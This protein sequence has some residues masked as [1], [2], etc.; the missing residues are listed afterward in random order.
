[1]AVFSL[2]FYFISCCWNSN[3]CNSF[4]LSDPTQ[5]Y[6]FPCTGSCRVS[7]FLIPSQ[8]LA[9]RNILV[10]FLAFQGR[11]LWRSQGEWTWAS[12]SFS[13]K[14]SPLHPPPPQGW[15]LWKIGLWCIPSSWNPLRGPLSQTRQNEDKPF[16]KKSAQIYFR[17]GSFL[18]TSYCSCLTG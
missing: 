11:P 14:S 5:W 7:C 6:T 9:P 13:F 2:I 17:K 3:K 1:M 12:S 10:D 8:T 18:I 4:G 15:S 16:F